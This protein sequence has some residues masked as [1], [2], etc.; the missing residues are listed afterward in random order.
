MFRNKRRRDYEDDAE[1]FRDFGPRLP[2]RQ[3][4]PPVVQLCKEMMPDICTI[5]ES[6]KAFPDDIKFLSEAIINE[7][8]HEA[9]FND[10]LLDTF[11]AVI[12]E[13]PQKQPA[14]ALLV[15]TVHA[16]NQIAGK[17]ILNFFFDELQRTCNT[18]VE[19]P[20]T[21]LESN[22]TGPWNKIK[23][24]LRFLSLLSPMLI[25]EDIIAVFKQMFDLAAELNEKT[26]A[27]RC[28]LAEEIYTNTL[29]N[30]PFLFYFKKNNDDACQSSVEEL[31]SHV[32]SSFVVKNVELKLLSEYSSNQTSERQTLVSLVLP[33]V[34]KALANNMDQLKNQLFCN[35]D[36]LLPEQQADQGFND[37]LKLP[38]ADEL[39]PFAKLNKGI[40]SVD[41]MWKVPRTVFHVYLPHSAGDFDTVV[42][43][44]TYAGQLFNDIIIDIVESLEFNR[45]EVAKQVAS[46]NLFFKHGIFAKTGESIAQLTAMYEE[47]PLVSTYKIEDLAIETILSLVF[48]L[49]SV[50]QPFAYFYTLLV[51]ICQNDP[52][53]IAPVFGRAFRF[54]YSRI[55]SLDFELRS[56]YLDWFSIQ[57]SNFNFLWK[58]NEWEEDSIKFRGSV[59]NPKIVF[60]RNLIRRELRLTSN[61]TEVDESLPQEFKQ[62]LDTSYVPV[63][64][65][66][67]FYQSLFGDYE[68]KVE[69]VEKNDLYFIQE[70][71]PVEPLAR[72]LIDYAHKQGS[73]KNIE[74]LEGLIEKLREEYSSIITDFDRF[75]IILLVQVV[76]H[77]GNRSLS[78]ANKYIGDLK[79]DLMTIFNK[80]D[81]DPATKE[82]IIIEAVLAYWNRN[83]QTGYLITDAL[84]F[85][86]LITAKS[87]ITF[88]FN[89]A[90]NGTTD[91]NYALTDITAIDTVY[92]SLSQ[93]LIIDPEDVT[94]FECVFEQ[95]VS[96]LKRNIQRLEANDEEE[97]LEPDLSPEVE[98][99]PVNDLPRLDQIWK[100]Y[101]TLGFMKSIL[102]KYAH[103]YSLLRDKF[104]NGMDE[105]LT[106]GPTK[107][108]VLEWLDEV[109]DL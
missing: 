63:S 15:M 45:K 104:V 75:L 23:L 43:M 95:L 12:L 91:K 22:D 41:S 39:L 102:R 108:L 101:A 85:A 56:R 88:C 109:T 47:D 92:R 4:I 25:L 40:G 86:G 81:M 70:G 98:I 90:A 7:Y 78:H 17:G 89:E 27:K 80:I 42:P 2:K 82:G 36:D 38:T 11:R 83:S 21:P 93:Q 50:S 52:R 35:W 14:I 32:E 64:S 62:Y 106:H 59:Y 20:T 30:I 5:G 57:M 60:I 97:I 99:D 65:L 16:G 107:R 28:P 18:T 10:A 13:Q 19:E 61:P 69:H 1:S 100:Y 51:D 9:Y 58:W 68:V 55:G 31:L 26:G 103:Q 84:K 94:L 105:V 76:V 77:S 67:S 46:L 87:V 37:S 74:E 24:L 33:N 71:V 49:P 72:Q 73:G 29:L 3:K 6:L 44:T 48:K 53:A 34:K 54:F 8:A 66:V 79:D 96:T